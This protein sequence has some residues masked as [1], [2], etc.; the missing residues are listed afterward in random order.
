MTKYEDLVPRFLK[1]VK[2]NTRS[3]PNSETIPSAAHE[4]P[5]LKSL[6]AELEALGMSDVKYNETNSYVTALLPANIDH[7]VPTIGFITHI[8][9]A[10]FNAEGVNPQIVENYDGKSVIKLDPEGN[11]V[12]DPAEFASLK[13]YAGH[14][15]IT[16]DGTT[17]LGADDKSGVAEVMTAMSYLIAHPEVK[18]GDIKV[19]FGPDEEIGTGADHFDTKDFNADFAYTVDGGPSGQLEYETFNAASFKLK[20]AGK[21][22]HPGSA[23]GILVS[24]IQ[25]GIDFQNQLPRTETPE[26]TDG[27]QGFFQLGNFN[28]TI[29]EANL[30]YIIRDFARDGLEKRKQLVRD[31]VT[32]MNQELGQDR[33]TLD[34]HDEY[35]NMV[36]VMKAHMD[37]V[38]L[39]EAAMAELNITPDEAPV[40]G[41]TDGSKLSFMGLPTPNLFAGG[42]NMHG[43]Y[44]YVSQQVMEQALDV[45]LKIIELNVKQNS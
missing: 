26:M 20:I 17:L 39:A 27:R 2:V 28:G 21:D 22:V 18:H 38:K 45:I 13:K 43:R 41:G 42:E 5:F 8:D 14:N 10:D 6:V 44:E 9:T 23:K 35:Y 3:N 12:L 31:I 11:Y 16:T 30:T 37:V 7:K 1:Y 4:V 19:G 40:R 33:L 29:D 15:L 34:M 32:K 36:E 25:L 24:A